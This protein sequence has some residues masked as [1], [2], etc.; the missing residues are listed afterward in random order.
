MVAAWQRLPEWD[1]LMFVSANAVAHFFALQP[2][3]LFDRTRSAQSKPRFFVTGPGS[4][5]ALVHM[6]VPP[7]RIDA[8]D[9]AHAQFDAAGG[10]NGG[11]VLAVEE[12][13]AGCR[14]E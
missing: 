13:I 11:D 12:I 2:E 6:H 1:A 4:L 10:G 9:A 7:Q 3:D 8:P 5:A 14:G